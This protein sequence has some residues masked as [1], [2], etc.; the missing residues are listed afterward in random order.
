M[1]WVGK[2]P[3]DHQVPAPPA[4]GRAHHPPDWVLDQAAQGPIQPGLEDL[5]GQSIHNIK[6]LIIRKGLC[7]CVIQ[8]V[9][10][11]I[12]GRDRTLLKDAPPALDVKTH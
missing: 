8:A 9:P 5:Q 6:H 1:P 12:D 2:D 3:M 4:T 10:P 7:L 11:G